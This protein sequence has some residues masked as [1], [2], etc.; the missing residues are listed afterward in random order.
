MGDCVDGISSF[1]DLKR[2]IHRTLCEK[3]NLLPDQFT[4]SETQLTRRGRVCGMRFS[5]RG[6]R[7][8]RLGAIWASD[9]N[10]IYF[11][12]ARGVRFRKVRLRNRLLPEFAEGAA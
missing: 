4:M 3:E 2:F 6:P 7:A 9:H 1:S 11:Y 10:Y 12:D 5:I 8:V